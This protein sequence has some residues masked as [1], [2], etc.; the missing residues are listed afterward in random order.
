[1]LAL[2]LIVAIGTAVVVANL[3]AR[4]AG[5]AVP[6]VLVA[7]GLLLSL[8]PAF[9]HVGLEPEVVLLLFLPPLLYWE[10]LT[11]SSR[12]IRRFIRGITLTG[13]LLVVVTAAAVAVVAH[14]LGLSWTTSWLIGAALAPTDATAVSALGTGLG[15]RSLTIL[16][17]ESLIND[18]TTLVVF[19]LALEASQHHHPFTVGHTAALAAR[20]FGGG[21]VVGLAVGW[22]A[23]QIR[24]R[25][26]DHTIANVVAVLSPFAA[27]LL[28]EEVHASG[29]VAVVL[30]GLLSAHLAPTRVT[31]AARTQ[32][33]PFWT[34]TTFGL[35][36][37]LFV[38]VGLELPDALGALPGSDIV[39]GIAVTAAVHAGLLATRLLFLLVSAGVIRALDRRPRQRELRTTNRARVVNTVAGFRGAVS[40]AVALAVPATIT[41]SGGRSRDM[42]VFVTAGVVTTSLV[43]QGLLLPRVIR[44]A[45]L[46]E[47]RSE[48]D[49]LALAW[50]TAGRETYEALPRMAAELHIGDDVLQWLRRDYADHLTAW[51][52]GN[53]HGEDDQDEASTAA[54]RLEQYRTLRLAALEHQR[55]AVVRLRNEGTIDDTVLRRVQD[56]LDAEEVRFRAPVVPE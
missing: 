10:S 3:A 23:I 1:M 6:V 42:V 31:A 15:R 33:T 43:L 11:T 47:D 12:E 25:I 26:D 32:Q 39:K 20:S 53:E 24:R 54:T 9:D 30:C 45:R 19:A 18:G 51:S 28:A 8:V 29:V 49:E 50:N 27:Y 22:L 5:V 52:A 14:L 36:G 34:L 7:L 44:W 17:A 55:H 35:N 56:R 48:A 21:I 16:R 37:A 40:L 46:P 4:R 41:T 13:I 38:L 2:Q